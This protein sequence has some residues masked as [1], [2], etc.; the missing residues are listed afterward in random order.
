[1]LVILGP[2]RLPQIGSIAGRRA[3]EIRDAAP[4]TKDA[5]LG[6]FNAG[7]TTG[8]TAAASPDPA[9]SPPPGGTAP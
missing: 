6:E 7:E 5:F 3:R 8:D 1:V 9:G 2:S 4:S